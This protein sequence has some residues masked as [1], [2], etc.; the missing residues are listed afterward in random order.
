MEASNE[1]LSIP[2]PC[3]NIT[4]PINDTGNQS[5]TIFVMEGIESTECV[6]S[7]VVNIKEEVK[8]C[9]KPEEGTGETKSMKKRRRKKSVIKR[10]NA[11]KKLPTLEQMEVTEAI[12]ENSGDPST[13][14]SAERSSLNSSQS[15]Q[16]LKEIQ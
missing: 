12:P 13:S 7:P 16:E 3:N 10:K 8:A 11:Q 9:P 6:S 15:E 2:L 5:E 4:L 14:D 1:D